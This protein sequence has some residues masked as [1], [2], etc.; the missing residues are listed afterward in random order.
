MPWNAIVNGINGLYDL[1]TNIADLALSRKTAKE[2]LKLQQEAFRYNQEWNDRVFRYQQQENN[3]MREREDTAM[4]R[5]AADAKLAGI[6]VAALTGPASAAGGGVTQAQML[7]APQEENVGTK[8]MATFDLGGIVKNFADVKKTLADAGYREK[9]TTWDFDESRKAIKKMT[10][11]ESLEQMRANNN[12][13]VIANEM[14]ERMKEDNIKFAELEREL[15]QLEVNIRTNE[16]EL[17]DKDLEMMRKYKIAPS[18]SEEVKH[19]KIM[20]AYKWLEKFD[21]DEQEF[22]KEY[23][24]VA[25]NSFLNELLERLEKS[26]IPGVGGLAAIIRGN[27]PRGSRNSKNSSY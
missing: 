13:L 23:H 7:E 12:A 22:I 6:N 17:S 16:K 19:A 8:N 21:G 15:K 1:G 24:R 5:A 3:L 25:E 11:L 4:Q 26:N 9:Q 2:N 27:L 20:T 10:E 14:A 18:D